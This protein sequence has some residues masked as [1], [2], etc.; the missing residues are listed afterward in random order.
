MMNLLQA[1]FVHFH[2]LLQSLFI[3][4]ISYLVYLMCSRLFR[5]DINIL[6]ISINGT[7]IFNLHHIE[8][9]YL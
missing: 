6:S 7:N 5:N 1:I 8:K 4:F 3:H 9:K 2:E